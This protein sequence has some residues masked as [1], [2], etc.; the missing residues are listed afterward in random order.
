MK[1]L[2]INGSPHAQGTTY[3]ALS[4]VAAELNRQDIQTEIFQLGTDPV[5]PCLGCRT[6]RRNN[7]EKCVRDGDVVNVLLD[8]VKEF[9]GYVFGSPVHYSSGCGA[10]STCLDRL[11]YA[12]N[13][14]AYKPGAVVVCCRRGGASSAFDHLNK[15]FTKTSMPVIS[16]QYW[17]MVYGD[18]AEDAK[19]DAE[20]LQTMRT[21]ARN[22]AWLLKCIDA[23]K[24][25]GIPMPETE[26][27]I[28]T[29]FIR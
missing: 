4:E 2:L 24:K 5:Y 20:G 29:N 18:N 8:K 27:G 15:Y 28:R 12:S 3:T 13:S 26:K 14:L 21:L 1:V 17:N 10:L 19:K 6:C 25:A 7:D 23:G 22:M 11:F 9:D 16:S